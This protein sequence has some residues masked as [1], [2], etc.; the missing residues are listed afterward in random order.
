MASLPLCAASNQGDDDSY[1]YDLGVGLGM[2]GYLGDINESNMFKHPGFA[3]QFTFRYM[4]PDARWAVRGVFTTAG[5]RGNS[6][7]F[8]NWLPGDAAYKFTSQIYDLG[9]RAEFNFFPYGIGETYKRLR[10][11]TPYVGVGLGITLASADGV[12]VTGSVPLAAGFKY[13]PSKR[14][15]LALEFCVSKTLGDHLDGNLSDLQGIKSDFLKNT[16]WHTGLMLSFT[17]EFGRR[18]ATCHYVD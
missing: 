16:D 17:Y 12:H 3:A 15:N 5:L 11:W 13:K 1:K 18:C 8:K 10:R 7:D 6:A 2:S 9:A 4:L 14:T